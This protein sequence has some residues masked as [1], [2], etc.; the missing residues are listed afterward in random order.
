MKNQLDY[1]EFI[2]RYLDSEMS[3]HELIWFEKE[4]DSNE[5]LQSELN[6]RKKVNNA[7]TEDR[8]MQLRNEIEEAHAQY[9]NAEKHLPNKQKRVFAAA[10]VVASFF[11]ALFLI[12]NLSVWNVSNNKLFDKYFEPYQANM[13]FRSADSELNSSLLT[14]M[15][16]YENKRY[17]EALKLFEEI[18]Q[19][20]PSRVGLNLYSGISKMEI[21]EYEN[22]GSS[23][24]KVIND[25][26][27]LYIEQAEWYL[28]LC[29]MITG[30]DDKAVKLLEKIVAENSFNTREAKKILRKL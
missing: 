4:L 11:L 12:L 17:K 15:Q 9:H 14:A 22:A 19:T 28:S 18:L 23:F 26:F 24:N 25:K 10:S 2:E 7:I 16:L 27:N 1:S 5:W 8:F 30:Q 21:H 3:G 29:Y 20:D 13:T 6:L